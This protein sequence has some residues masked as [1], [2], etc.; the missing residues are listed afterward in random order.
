MCPLPSARLGFLLLVL[1]LFFHLVL[2][3]LVVVLFCF[4]PPCLWLI[5]GVMLIIG[6]SNVSFLFLG[7]LFVP[8]VFIALIATLLETSSWMIFTPRLTRLFPLSL[9]EILIPFLTALLIALALIRQTLLA[10]VPLPF[11]DL[12]DAC[13]V[14]DI[15][16]YLHPSSSSFTWTRWNSSLASRIDLFGVPYVWVSSVSSC[17]ILPC[18]FSDHCAVSLSI[19]I[20]DVVAPGPGLWKL[21]ISILDE[22]EYVK[23]IT[24]F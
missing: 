21:N 18:L 1:I 4:V 8:V 22:V 9:L 12:F 2:L 15:W 5:P 3:I 11:R 14:V 13:C 24:D 16:R 20:P 17:D 10:R 23:I 6:L 7:S 19:S